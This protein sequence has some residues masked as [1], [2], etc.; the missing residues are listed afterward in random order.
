MF[1][2]QYQA[3]ARAMEALAVSSDPARP[4]WY[5]TKLLPGFLRREEKR[6]VHSRAYLHERTVDRRTMQN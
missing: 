4:R 6:P 5:H 1:T 2:N 3:L